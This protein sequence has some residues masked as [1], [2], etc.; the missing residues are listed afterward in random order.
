MD[1]MRLGRTGI[2]TSKSGFGA[3]PIQR[4]SF[5][6]A[7][8]LLK[9]AYDNGINYFDTARGY[10]D[11][12]EKIAYALGDVRRDIFIATKTMATNKAGLFE[13]LETSLKML[14]TDVIDVYQ[15]HN[16]GVLD[17]E[18]TDGLYQGLLEARQKGYIRYLGLTN[19]RIDVALQAARDK[20]FD[21][22][23]FPLNTLSSP[24]DLELIE[25]CRQN[26][27]GL[28]AMKGMSGGLITNAASAFAFLRQ[29][30]NVLPI[31]GVQ[32]ESELD[33]FLSYEETPP[34]LDDALQAV[35]DHDRKELGGAFCRGCGYCKPCPANIPID[36]AARIS[37]LLTRA[38]YERFLSD[39]FKAEMERIN[40]CIHCDHCKNNCPYGLDTPA[41]LAHM[42]NEYNQ[43]Y[44]INKK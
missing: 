7:A 21:T 8:Y 16:P 39:E 3:L 22:I 11:S 18:D 12:E 43:F 35:I 36:T 33:E 42:L 15:L 44:K 13:H 9:K 6:D 17:Y 2:Q 1:K 25:V 37:L 29:F 30:G 26:D 38:P 4:I 28:I 41:L 24:K 34:A 20:K 5:E 32:R 10:T 19:H 27:I 23:Q 31:W 40:D 14:N